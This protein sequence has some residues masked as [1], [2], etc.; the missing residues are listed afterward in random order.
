[1]STDP[2]DTA[3]AALVA[4]VEYDLDFTSRFERLRT[5]C[6]HARH[7]IDEVPGVAEYKP[8]CV[9]NHVQVASE[10]VRLIGEALSKLSADI[11][12]WDG[13]L[14]D[15]LSRKFEADIQKLAVAIAA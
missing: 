3:F 8:G 14:Q 1:M 15:R 4:D 2:I 11:A 5:V 7:M 13:R 9:E 12:D 10:T 6:E